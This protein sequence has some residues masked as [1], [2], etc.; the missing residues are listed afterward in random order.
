MIKYWPN[1]P[2]IKLNNAIVELFTITEKKIIY[3]LSNATNSYLYLDILNIEN[4]YKLLKLI[5]NE[6]KILILDLIELNLN[7]QQLYCLDKKIFK[8]FLEKV[9]DKF[10]QRKNQQ[11]ILID[12]NNIY[13]VK[14]LINYLLFGSSRIKYN[15][16]SFTPLY[17]PYYHVQILFEN[18][19]ISTANIIINNII[20]DL[21]SSSSI[22][23]F[24][25]TSNRCNYIYTSN[26]SITLFLNNLRWQNIINNYICNT[27]CLYNE[28]EKILLISS[29]GIITKYIYTSNVKRVKCLNRF[30]GFILFWLEIKDIIIPKTEKILIRTSKYLVYFLINFLSNLI[31][32]LLRFIIFYLSK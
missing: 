28:R 2:S 25:K 4:R 18:F 16:F 7:E 32:T 19:I 24:F 6:F 20:E 31:I 3:N 27:K 14:E 30:Q 23:L 10:E 29:E 21:K 15:L 22:Y 9:L 11:T 1:Q 17:T 26:R 5:L 12:I 13:L 8:I